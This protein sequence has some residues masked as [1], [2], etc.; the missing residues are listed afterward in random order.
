MFALLDQGST[1]TF[2]TEE[3]VRTLNIKGEKTP[4][5][6]ATLGKQITQ[7]TEVVTLQVQN[8]NHSSTT[9]L[10][11]AYVTPAIPVNRDNIAVPQDLEPYPHLADLDLPSVPERRVS[12]LIGQDNSQ[13]FFPLEVIGGNPGEPYAT[14]TPLGWTLHGPLETVHSDTN[15]ANSFNIVTSECCDRLHEDLQ[16]MWKVESSE[17]YDD[18]EPLSPEEQK[19]AELWETTTT[20]EDGRYSMAIPFKNPSPSLPNSLEMAKKRLN[21]L[22]TRLQKDASLHDQ[23]NK[24]MQEVLHQ[25]YAE[26]V[27][28]H[29]QHREDWKVW[30]VPHHPFINPRRQKIRV[31]YDCAAQSQGQS[32]NSQVHTGPDRIQSLVGILLRFRLGEVA[33][34]ADIK[35]MYHQVAVKKDDRDVLRFLWWPDGDLAQQPKMYRMCRHL[36]GGRWSPSCCTTALQFAVKRS[37]ALT[38]EEQEEVLQSFYV[39]DYLTSVNSATTAI[40]RSKAVRETLNERGFLLTKWKS[41]NNKVLSGLQEPSRPEE[42]V[43]IHPSDESVERALGIVWNLKADVLSYNVTVSNKHITRRG[44]LSTLSSIFD[45]LGIASP[46]IL[47]ARL[48]VQQLCRDKRG[49]D[50][51]VPSQ[52]EHDWKNWM[53]EL[54]ELAQF[55]VPT[56][57]AVGDPHAEHQLHHFCDA[58]STAYGVVTYLVTKNHSGLVTSRILAAK[59]RLAPLKV[60]SVPRLE[61]MGATLAA[62]QDSAIKRELKGRVTLMPSHFW[63]DSMI[64]LQYINNE[65]RRF[66]TFVAN[67]IA[68]IR[69][70]CSPGQWHHV[71]TEV[72]PADDCSRGLSPRQ[73]MTPRWLQGPAFLSGQRELVWPPFK[74]SPISEQDPEV[75]REKVT[76]L[77]ASTPNSPVLAMIL[78]YSDWYKLRRAVAWL[79]QII[80]V[81]TKRAQPCEKLPFSSLEEAELLIIKTVQR[82]EYE[83]ELEELKKSNKTSKKSRLR[84]LHPMLQE[85]V[86]RVGGRLDKAPI[87]DDAKHPIILPSNHHASTLIIRDVHQRL[88]HA[89][90]EHVLAAVREKYWM[91]GGRNA[92]RRVLGHCLV[93]RKREG[94]TVSQQMADLPQDRVTP[95]GHPF[96][97]TGVDV[98]GP[99]QVKYRRGRVVR[100]I[101]LF[102]CL[103]TRAVH[104]EVIHDLTA[105]SFLQAMQRFTARRGRVQVIR[106]DNGRNF[107]RAAKEIKANLAAWKA[108]PAVDKKLKEEGITWI[109]NPPY[110][111]SHGGVW[112]RQIRSVRRVLAGLS[113]E[114]VLTDQG[115]LTLM[116]TVENIINSRP[117]T[118][119]SSDPRDLNPIT[120]NHLLIPQVSL[121][122]GEPFTD[123][124]AAQL[125]RRQ[126]QQINLLADTFWKRWVKEY[127][128]ELQRRHKWQRRERGLAPGDVVL[129]VDSGTPRSRWKLGR[130]SESPSKD[131]RSV[132]VTTSSGTILRPIQKL[133]LLEC[134]SQK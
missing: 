21:C 37:Q 133:C 26:E 128:P 65:A 129:V 23:Y 83:E 100:H 80:K 68:V 63:T 74:S 32:L 108:S 121:E 70:I 106:S 111:S 89:G 12:L 87:P 75:K 6:L 42:D 62:R 30:Y 50:E 13:C 69:E 56:W 132:R 40:E 29:E 102:T 104:L 55:Q 86:L 19:V 51:P 96:R 53:Q 73:L 77:A 25:G 101:C 92:V 113:Q 58:S 105:D 46:F 34:A 5:S 127:L 17:L 134:S 59:S 14:R 18:S 114:Q 38:S 24:A 112:E 64:V 7:D 119:V 85:N 54:P 131:K 1:A 130:V 93:C 109:F 10:K 110:A 88:G 95:G 71:G 97:S 82:E 120:P 4:L 117:L 22:A 76:C 41:N 16:A 78:H 122:S 47:K 49:W 94:P 48:I 91:V 72:N 66:Q 124:N 118:T 125:S 11:S 35:A 15:Q 2:C 43:S 31:V 79:K 3:L 45:P 36:F 67:R 116:C 103:T 107:V 20:V 126:L 27:P 44:M 39:D 33:I 8:E 84:K 98:F 123:P 28:L 90:R 61:L 52:Q 57:M 99:F 115:L 9:T 60:V 81:K